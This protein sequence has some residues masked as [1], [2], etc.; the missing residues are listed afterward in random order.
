MVVAL[1]SYWAPKIGRFFKKFVQEFLLAFGG[2]GVEA[3][4]QQLHAL[5]ALGDHPV[6]FG[7]ISPSA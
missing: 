5:N 1:R 2:R 3:K 6:V 7:D 4:G